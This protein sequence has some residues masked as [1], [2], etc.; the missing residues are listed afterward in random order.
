VADISQKYNLAHSTTDSG[1]QEENM[2]ERTDN[3][4]IPIW[5]RVFCG[6]FTTA[7]LICIP[8]VLWDLHRNHIPYSQFLLPLFGGAGGFFLFA[9]V[10]LKGRM[11]DFMTRQRSGER[12][13]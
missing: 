7:M 6:L 12:Q 3:A 9:F 10:A 5:Q 8:V 1:A 13:N 11:P 4:A 2:L